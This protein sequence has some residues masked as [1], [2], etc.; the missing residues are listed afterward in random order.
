MDDVRFSET[1]VHACRSQ[2]EYHLQ[3]LEFKSNIHIKSTFFPLL[4]YM[5]NKS[6]R[7]LVTVMFENTIQI[8]IQIKREISIIL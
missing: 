8:D 4:L 3:S 1:Y 7:L 6:Y 5:P 2:H